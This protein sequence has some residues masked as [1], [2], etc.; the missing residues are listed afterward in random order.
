MQLSFEYTKECGM[1]HEPQ[2]IHDKDNRFRVI[3]LDEENTVNCYEAVPLLGLYNNLIFRNYG[4]ISPDEGVVRPSLK[5]V[6]HYG[7][8]GFWS[9]GSDHRFVVYMMPTDISKTLV[10][11]SISFGV[12][13]EVSSLN[14]KLLNV[15]GELLNRH[16]AL[17]TPGTKLEV[18]F[19]LGSSP[20]AMLGVFYIDRAQVSYPE[21]SVS[22]TARNAIGKLLKEQT[23]DE[24]TVF[25]F[26]SLQENI[27]EILELA[28]VESYF[29]GDP[30][31]EQSLEFKRDTTLLEGLKYAISLLANWKIGETAEGVVGVAPATDARF[32]PPE[33]YAFSRDR[34][35]WSYSIEYDDK[36]AASRVCVYSKGKEETDPEQVVYENVEFN[37]WWSQPEHRTLY[38]QTVDGASHEQVVSVAHLLAE[39][40]AASGRQETFAGIFTPQLT[41]GD[42]VHVTDERGGSEVIGA[43][44][45]VTHNFGQNGFYTQF[46][47][48]SG[49]RRGRTRLKDLITNVADFPEAFTGVHHTTPV[50]HH[51]VE[52][53]NAAAFRGTSAETYTYNINAL[54]GNLVVAHCICRTP[55]MQTPEGWTRLFYSDTLI[56]GTTTQYSY[57]FYKETDGGMTS[58]TFNMGGTFW[59]IV[60]FT[61]FAY[62][63][64][65][66]V[67]VNPSRVTAHSMQAQK[68]T[69]DPAIWAFHNIYWNTGTGYKWTVSGV[70][71]KYISQ[72]DDFPR[73]LT[74]CDVGAPRIITATDCMTG[75]SHIIESFC[76]AIATQN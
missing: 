57:V 65:P 4:R 18:Y 73:L 58:A 2:A 15:R 38:V 24:Q 1:G 62:A 26:G 68:N 9:A 30:G 52:F 35:C 75:D 16:R 43:V 10:D 51:D 27:R 21:E 32:D 42:E 74:V 53:R 69:Y 44:T 67:T 34:N 64:M 47:V 49:G 20:E 61:A 23:F 8:Y 7:A 17:V 54:G 50:E 29:V 33:V 40:L 39:S 22:I 63:G 13:S 41:T 71:D 3:Y 66:Y 25:D 37:K 19:S 76:I 48:D 70:E 31:V 5:R 14:C 12:G 55:S 46:T 36:D 56:E 45:D 6:A 28:E 72:V 11:G 60:N 59:L